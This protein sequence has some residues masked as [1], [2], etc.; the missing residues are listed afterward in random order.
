[1]CVCVVYVHVVCVCVYM[2]KCVCVDVSVCVC[3]MVLLGRCTRHPQHPTRE[4]GVPQG[5]C[6]LETELGRE[7]RACCVGFYS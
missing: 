2:C 6:V 4:A 5:D 3:V 7:A 1:M